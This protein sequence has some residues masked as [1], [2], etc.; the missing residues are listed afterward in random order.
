MTEHIPERDLKPRARVALSKAREHDGLTQEILGNRLG[1]TQATISKALSENTSQPY[2]TL[3]ARIIAEC[4][5][6]IYEGSYHRFSDGNV[7]VTCQSRTVDDLLFHPGGKDAVLIDYPFVVKRKRDGYLKDLIFDVTIRV[8][9]TRTLFAILRNRGVRTMDIVK[10]AYVDAFH[11]RYI[12][13][14]NVAIIENSFWDIAIM[15]NSS[16]IPMLITVR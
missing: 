14:L 13:I 1:V 12:P 3:L 2:A 4:E 11:N 7:I 5:Q 15:E 10:L 9:F 6:K 16:Y 8:I